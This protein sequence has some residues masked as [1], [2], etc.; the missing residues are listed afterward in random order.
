M[1]TKL[2]VGFVAI[3]IVGIATYAYLTRPVSAPSE[4]GDNNTP[5][6]S[7]PAGA[8]VY[9]ISEGSSVQ[10]EISE[11]LNGSPNYVVGTTN[12]IEGEVAVHTNGL[13]IGTIAVNARTL[14]TD[15]DRRD[16]AVARFILK[17]EEEENEFITFKN[18]VI[19][20][21]QKNGPTLSFTATGDLTI[22]GITKSVAFMGSVTE[23]IDGVLYGTAGT[24]IQR[25]DFDLRIPSVP[26]VANVSPTVL[27]KATIVA[28]PKL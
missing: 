8:K 7:A 1:K 17:S 19:S 16:N 27:L 13:T 15:R 9:V 22:A 3:L 20:T 28:K 6:V 11:T 4:N 24:E 14:K 10:Y 12:A 18:I 21:A 25:A 26:G 23:N 2:I 5:T